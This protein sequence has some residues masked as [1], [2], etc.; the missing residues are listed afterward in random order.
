MKKPMLPAGFTVR[1][2]TVEDAPAM[3]ALINGSTFAE[4]GM[5]WTTEQE[6]H[7][8]LTAPEHDPETD[9]LLMFDPDGAP[10]GCLQLWADVAPYNEMYALVHTHPDAWGKGVSSYLLQIGEERARAKIERVPTDIRVVVQAG[11]FASDADGRRL[12]ENPGFTQVRTFWTMQ[13]DLEDEPPTP[14][15]P[16]GLTIRGFDLERDLEAAHSAFSE[17]FDDHWGHAFPSLEIWKHFAIEGEGSGFDPGLLFVAEDGDQIVGVASSRV[18]RERDAEYAMVED[19]GVRRAWRRRGVGLALA[20]RSFQEIARRGIKRAE[21]VVDS[22]NPTG[23]TR[24][25]ERAGM[26]VAYAREIWEKELRG[27]S[28]APPRTG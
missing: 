26:Q 2:P 28:P 9:D 7:D 15:V 25:Y 23:A 22:D 13:T 14:T 21:L 6:V 1:P 4:I 27:G 24:L 20:I 10:V 17:A 3:A 16:P 11:C 8:D 12:L 18:R 5:P 19:L